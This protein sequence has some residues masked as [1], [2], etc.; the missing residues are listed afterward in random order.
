MPSGT[1]QRL[2]EFLVNTTFEDIPVRVR[3]IA[4]HSAL[5]TFGVAMAGT[6]EDSSKII[7]G[8]VRK[9]GGSPEA[10]V[11]G[12]GFRTS[13]PYAGL[14]N[15]TITNALDYDD[16]GLKVG[17][18]SVLV[19]PTLA[20]LGHKLHAPGKDILTAYILAVEV[21][22]KVSLACNLATEKKIIQHYSFLGGFGAAA[23][24]AK[25]LKLDARATRT[26]FAVAVNM[27]AGLTAISQGSWLSPCKAGNAAYNGIL[28][29]L[30]AQES[31]GISPGPKLDVVE[32]K[33]G[34]CDSFV[35][36]GNYDL[37]MMTANLGDPYYI[38]S[39][40]ITVKKY[41]SCFIT[42]RALDAVLQLVGENHLSPED[43]AGVEVGMNKKAERVLAFPRPASGYEGKFS[44]P[45]C[46]ASAIVDGKV[47]LATFT[48]EKLNRPQVKQMM[49]RV[50][51]TYPDL[52]IFAGLSDIDIS[53][54]PPLGNPITVRLKNGKSYS[55]RV[56]VPKGSPEAP[57]S[58][59]ELV[60]KYSEC[61]RVVL[62]PEDIRRT[63][64]LI[65]NLEKVGDFGEIM[66]ILCHL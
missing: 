20:S 24:A 3:N 49:A 59:N 44:M 9:L 6:L 18:P 39:P 66:D 15:G 46:V 56:D 60:A 25:L 33:G 36:P 4:K 2:A 45:Y 57:L 1:T 8:L 55:T 50:S 53:E 61:A 12:Q 22:G 64:D 11:I 32:M 10:G 43:I 42:H 34:L 17:H 14:A 7:T 13:A 21:M 23:A 51:T 62:P 30:L 35:G 47:N 65:L 28:A 26:A 58:D 31:A 40:G 41:P 29:T 48:D 16:C 19:L 38:E 27:A 52:P 5:D 63:A 37:D 54:A